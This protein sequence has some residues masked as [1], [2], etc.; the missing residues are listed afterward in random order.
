MYDH[1]ESNIKSKNALSVIV[2]DPEQQIK[3]KS[4]RSDIGF[5]DFQTTIEGEYEFSF[6]NPGGPPKHIYVAVHFHN[7]LDEELPRYDIDETGKAHKISGTFKILPDDVLAEEDAEDEAGTA[8]ES[9]IL[10]RRQLSTGMT[11]LN[12][13]KEE[14]KMS[15][16]R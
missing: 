12:S 4:T 13:I 8:D 9:I 2:R 1:D 5:V 7:L 16:M 3:Y 10:M 11:Q 15:M 14:S 6:L